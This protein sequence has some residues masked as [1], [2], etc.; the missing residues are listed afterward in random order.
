MEVEA[1]QVPLGQMVVDLSEEMAV[2]EL[3]LQLLELLF[4]ELEEE[5]VLLRGHLLLDLVDLVEEVMQELLV[6]TM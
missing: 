2:L 6:E 5:E 1:A 3:A 4:S